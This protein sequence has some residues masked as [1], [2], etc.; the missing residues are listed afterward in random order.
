L[1]ALAGRVN[2]DFE[3]ELADYIAMVRQEVGQDHITGNPE[4]VLSAMKHE[5]FL[6]IARVEFGVLRGLEDSMIVAEA[7][8]IFPEGTVL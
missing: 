2:E 4:E 5:R 7:N 1:Q 3:T 8:R 6:H